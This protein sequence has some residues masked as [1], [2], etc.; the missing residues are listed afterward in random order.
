MVEAF[1]EI[2]KLLDK[3]MNAK[4]PKDYLKARA[5]QLDLTK[6][7]WGD[8]KVS[9]AQ[10]IGAMDDYHQAKSKEEDDFWFDEF[11]Y[12]H[13]DEVREILNA[14]WRDLAKSRLDKPFGKE[15]NQ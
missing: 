3:P 2:M 7:F 12:R 5:K 1:F 15:D 11:N 13:P 6:P 8:Q 4:E 9:A 10:A 14:G